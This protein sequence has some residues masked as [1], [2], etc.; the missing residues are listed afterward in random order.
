MIGL[1][2]HTVRYCD[3]YLVQLD[4]SQ[5]DFAKVMGVSCVTDSRWENGRFMPSRMALISVEAYCDRMIQ[6]GWLLSDGL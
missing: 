5:E 6:P 4:L 1:V 3:T 2:D